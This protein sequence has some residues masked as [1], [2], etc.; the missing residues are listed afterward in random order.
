[1]PDH[2][3]TV[4]WNPLPIYLFLLGVIVVVGFPAGSYPA[5]VLSAFSPIQALKGKLKLGKGVAAFRQALVVVQFSISVF[6]IVG[7]IIITK[8]MSYVKKATRL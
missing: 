4:S 8:Q 2:S 3:P 7:T 5:V 1:M 6:R